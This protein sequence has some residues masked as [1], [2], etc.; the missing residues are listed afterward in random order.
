MWKR[1]VDILGTS[2]LGCGRGTGVVG[3]V[4]KPQV[5]STWSPT[6]PQG[7]YLRIGGFSTV[8]T[9]LITRYCELIYQREEQ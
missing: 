6:G 9:D 2:A 4:E 5:G 8:S 3:D 1:V 7:F